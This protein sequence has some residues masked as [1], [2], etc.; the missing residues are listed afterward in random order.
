[1]R[2]NISGNIVFKSGFNVISRHYNLHLTRTH[3]L[4]FCTKHNSCLYKT[5]KEKSVVFKYIVLIG[6]RN[7]TESLYYI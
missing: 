3:F 2:I 5:A 1:M 6:E 7:S 4:I